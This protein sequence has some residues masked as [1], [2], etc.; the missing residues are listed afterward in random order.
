M[1]KI[2]IVLLVWLVSPLLLM[3]TDAI[4]PAGSGTAEDPYRISSFSE[5][6]WISKNTS[7]WN[8]SFVQTA[9]IDAS[10]TN[11]W[12]YGLSPIGYIR[13]TI[14]QYGVQHDDYKEFGG[15]YDGQGHIISGLYVR[16]DANSDI[17]LF[18]VLTSSGA[19]RNLGLT[20]CEVKGYT[21]VGG[22]VGLL[23]G[24]T[25]ENCFTTGSVGYAGSS[26][27]IGGLVGDNNWG[28]ISRSYSSCSLNGSSYAGGLAG[29]SNGTV[30]D[31]YATGSV[32]IADNAGG[33]SCY[34]GGLLGFNAGSVSRCYSKGYVSADETKGGMVGYNNGTVDN[35]CFWDVSTSERSSGA[36]YNCGTFN[37]L[38]K[39]TADIKNMDLFINAGWNFSSVWAMIGC[40]YPVF[41]NYVSSCSDPA[42][43]EVSL[44]GIK[45]TAA[46]VIAIVL[47]KGVPNSVPCGFCYSSTDS[48][49][50][51]A[52]QTYSLGG[53][54][55]D[56]GLVTELTG[57]I[58]GK[59]YF[60]RAFAT[61]PKSGK[62]VYSPSTLSIY[63]PYI[64]LTT[65][66]TLPLAVS[67]TDSFLVKG[68]LPFTVA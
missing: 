40:D 42:V 6:Y 68:S 31:C 16:D 57:L 67:Y 5:L 61:N 17:G 20:G 59:T 13:S 26:Q 12:K 44:V 43:S 2:C 7:A 15:T 51:I 46:T 30:V 38:G 4:K 10:V 39:T 25:V 36:G 28:K 41:M 1:K 21:D 14:D 37:A 60:V 23:N 53:A 33:K 55:N 52:N 18:G 29:S 11:D 64:E 34:A 22:L 56:R 62:T 35:T 47:S 9:D 49:P 48:V 66:D 63:Y 24:G 27:G 65:S 8:A 19:V 54:M 3:A 45:P 58:K 50:T 32:K